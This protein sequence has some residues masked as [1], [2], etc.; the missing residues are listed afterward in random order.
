MSGRVYLVGAGPGDPGLLTLRGQRCVAQADVVVHDDLVNRR[1]LDYARPGAEIVDVGRPHG[2]PGRLSQAAIAEL[3]VTHARC[4]QVVVRLKN[5]DPFLFGR[6]AEE[7]RVLREAG[8]PYDIV[9]GVS[10]ALAV[11]A[12]AGIPATDREHASLVTIV[13]GHF[14]CRDEQA[15]G[16]PG[17]PWDALVRQGGTLVVLMGVKHL[18]AI[19]E[20]LVRH[21]LAADTP[22]AVI[23]RGTTGRQRTIVATVATIAGAAHAA[24]VRSPAVVVVGATV[25]LR[26]RIAWFEARPLVGRRI[27]VTRPRAQAGEVATALEDLGAEVELFPTIEIAP[28]PDAGALD[29][30]VADAGTYDWIVFTSVNGVR[31]FFERMAALG[32]DV[33]ELA[34]TRIAAIGPETASELERRLVRPAVVPAEYRAEGLLVVLGEEAIRGRRV[35]LPRAAGARAVLPDT[36]RARGA[37]VDEVVAYAAVPPPTADVEG[38]RALIEADALDAITFTSS[39]TVRNFAAL[40][41]EDAMRTLARRARPLVACIGPVT[42]ETAREL[43]LRVDVVPDA[44]TVPALVGALAERFCNVGIDPL[45]EGTG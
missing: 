40:L 19:A 24:G 42:A 41:G 21:G 32:R 14:A 37:V 17:L 33:R 43:G 18:A 10:S 27:L 8:I 1:L 5:G 35:L 9:P 28:A 15:A 29:R 45:S 2:G 39:S 3:L 22:A 44:Y 4:G 36:L 31:V 34:T 30:A 25:T 6:G 20:A 11:P 12:Y 23:E 16:T 13:T 26:D 38:L 7:A